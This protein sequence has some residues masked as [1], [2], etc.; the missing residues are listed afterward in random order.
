MPALIFGL[1]N[2]ILPGV[3]NRVLPPEKMSEEDSAKLQQELALE[4]MKQDWQG[5][6]AE[7]ADRSNARNLAA[8]DIAGGNN[9]TRFLS[10]TVRPAWGFGALVLVSYSVIT[11]SAIESTYA[12][13]IQTV[14]FFYFGGR[15]LEKVTPTIV[16]AFKK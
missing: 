6:E 11:H 14:L 12:D 10:A 5:I 4:L 1:L 9:I 13:I 16:G 3:I 7:Y 2:S 15:T 8:Q